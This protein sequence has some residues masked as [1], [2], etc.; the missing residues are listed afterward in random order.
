MSVSQSPSCREEVGVHTRPSFFTSQVHFNFY[1]F[2]LPFFSSSLY[3][4][5]FL[6]SAGPNLSTLDSCRNL[7][8]F[9]T[10]FPCPTWARAA[11]GYSWLKPF[12]YFPLCSRKILRSSP[13]PTRPC[14]Q[15]LLLTSSSQPHRP[16]SAPTLF[17]SS[18]S[19]H[20]LFLPPSAL[21][22]WV[23]AYRS[24]QRSSWFL[25]PRKSYDLNTPWAF[26]PVHL[27]SNIDGISAINGLSASRVG[28]C[29][30]GASLWAYD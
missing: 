5:C 19:W 22:L 7:R 26:L 13:L 10:C 28:A 8:G 20:I 3:L 1:P 24:P 6:S 15:W 21:F 27:D 2:Y 18:G 30:L 4:R 25:N 12:N 11:M 23:S 14:S 9:S 29:L 16:P 17:P